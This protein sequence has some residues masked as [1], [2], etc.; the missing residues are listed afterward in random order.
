MYIHSYVVSKSMMS[1][2]KY[3]CARMCDM[4]RHTTLYAS[5]VLLFFVNKFI[6]SLS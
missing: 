1:L 2:Y 5:P 3:L 6:V 4:R